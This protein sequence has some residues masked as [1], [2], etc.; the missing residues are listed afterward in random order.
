MDVMMDLMMASMM[1]YLMV[2]MKACV[3]AETMDWMLVVLMD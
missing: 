3:T 2:R 1:V